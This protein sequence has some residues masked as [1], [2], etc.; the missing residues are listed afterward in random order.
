M[1]RLSV[2]VAVAVAV[3]MIAA[4]PESRASVRIEHGTAFCVAGEL[5]TLEVRANS[6]DLLGRLAVVL[7]F[8]NTKMTVDSVSNGEFMPT[9]LHAQ[10]F[11]DVCA[12]S[13]YCSAPQTCGEVQFIGGDVTNSTFGSGVLFRVTFFAYADTALTWGPCPNWCDPP[14]FCGSIGA[15]AGSYDGTTT[16]SMSWTP[17]SIFYSGGPLTDTDGDGLPDVVETYFGTNP[18]DADSDDDGLM[19][20]HGFSEDL[21]NNGVVDPGETDPRDADSDDDGIFDATEQGKTAPETPDTDLSAG[22]FVADADPT[23]TTDP[24][25]PDSDGDGVLDGLED[26][27]GNGAFEPELGEGDPEDDASQP[28]P[29]PINASARVLL[30]GDGDAEDQVQP[31]LEAAGHTV[32]LVDYYYDWDGVTPDLDDFDMVVLLDGYDYGYELQEAAASALQSFVARGCGL[33]MTEWTAYDVCEEDKTGAIADL[34]PVSSAPD[35]DYDYD[36]TWLVTASHVLTAGV[37]TSWTD[38]AS[39]SEVQPKPGTLVVMRTDSD[40]PLLSYSTLAGGNVVHLNHTM[41]YDTSTIEPNALQLIVNAVNFASY[42]CSPAAADSDSDG[43]PLRRDDARHRRPRDAAPDPLP[44][45][46]DLRGDALGSA[47]GLHDRRG[48]EARRDR[49]PEQALRRERAGAHHWE[50]LREAGPGSGGRAA[51]R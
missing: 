8:D 20:G 16:Y 45:R 25:N 43:D 22:Y 32:T 3:L 44:G 28:D 5:C 36:L 6:T 47:R 4:T 21:N 31:A 23:S 1:K 49:L 27:N 18:Y 9:Q 2:L 51:Q 7:R 50:D 42:P 15:F 41:T 24:T 35:C 17:G 39:S 37:P 10:S 33:L 12:H 26:P 19:D 14:Y 48:D 40:I 11:N 38:G 34:L 13:I 46:G 30:L 29:A